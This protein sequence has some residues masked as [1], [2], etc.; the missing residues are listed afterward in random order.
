MEEKKEII[1]DGKFVAFA[2]TLKDADSGEV[3]FEAKPSA[4][5]VMVYGVSQEVIPGLLATVK[6]LGKGDRFSV[7]LPPE[8]AFG[9]RNDE[10]VQQVPLEAFMRDGKM[11][12]EVK[13][14]SVLDMMT[15]TGDIISGRVVKVTP[16]FVEMDFNHPFAGKTVDFEGEI[17]EVRDATEEE[18]HPKHS[19]GCGCSHH[20]EE[21][22]GECS[23]S[24]GCGDCGGCH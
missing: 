9:Q 24:C 21:N 15:N 6:G 4:P 17:I 19:C 10:Y 7:T 13:E 1:D 2:Y 20:G 16:D 18:M 8:V 22:D 11:A 23:G 5:D 14:G 3:L 12:V